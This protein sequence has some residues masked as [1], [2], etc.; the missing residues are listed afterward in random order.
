[1]TEPHRYLLDTTVLIDISKNIE[2]TV[3]LVSEWL[4]GPHEVGVCDIVIAEFFSGAPSAQRAI[5]SRFFARLAYW[6]I[7]PDVAM[8]AGIYRHQ[9]AR[10]GKALSTPDVLIVALAVSLGA[11]LV[12]SNA[13]DFP[14]PELTV[15]QP[16]P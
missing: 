8:Q 12:T 10:I 1:M 7:A 15:I 6:T 2:P 4:A 16:R 11:T 3:A 5:W 14:M 13:D 9:H